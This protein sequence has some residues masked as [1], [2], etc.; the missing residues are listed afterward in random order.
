ML[1]L[2]LTGCFVTTSDMRKPRVLCEVECQDCQSVHLTCD[3]SNEED[4]GKTKL[5]R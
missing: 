3:F 1:S 2:L 5:H 4:A